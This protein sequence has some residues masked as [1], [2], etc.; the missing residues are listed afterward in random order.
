M[1]RTWEQDARLISPFFSSNSSCFFQFPASDFVNPVIQSTITAPKYPFPLQCLPASRVAYFGCSS[2]SIF[3]HL[4]LNF[5]WFCVLWRVQAS[6]SEIWIYYRLRMLPWGGLSCCLSAAALYLLGRSSGRSVLVFGVFLL[7]IL[8]SMCLHS[9]RI[10][11]PEV[12]DTHP[13]SH[14]LTFG[15]Y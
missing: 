13:C 5:C 15:L 2:R 9:A 3:A 10:T 12:G 6:G 1:G 14:E 4:L 7:S 8:D 11:H